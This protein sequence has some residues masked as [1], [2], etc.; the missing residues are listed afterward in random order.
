MTILSTIQDACTVVG[1]AVPSTVYGSTEREH[2]ELAALANEMAQRIAFD[3]HDWTILKTLGT[4][5]GDGSATT[6]ARPT[7]YRRMLK[8]AR[9]WPSAAPFSP[10]VHVSDTD[11]W[12]GYDVQN[13]ASAVGRWTLI[14]ESINVK[15]AV[16]NLATVK[17]YY[18]SK[19]IVA[20]DTGSNKTDFTIDTDV[21]RL[22]EEMLKL[23]IIWQWKANKGRPYAED[24]Q[25]YETALAMRIGEDKGSNIITVG[26]QRIPGDVRI[27]YPGVIVG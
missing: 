25:N 2:V 10:L 27:A 24:M 6:F 11:E 3:T 5:T 23:G 18:L 14:G 4:L 16:A 13:F 26:Q 1:L 17:F 21:F 9:L 8:K 7:D 15:P 20:P 12:L 19:L 22:D